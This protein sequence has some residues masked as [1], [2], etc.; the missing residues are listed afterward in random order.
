MMQANLALAALPFTIVYLLQ[1]LYRIN[2]DTTGDFVRRSRARLRR[3]AMSCL[4]AVI[5]CPV[6]SLCAQS[7]T[8]HITQRYLNIPVERASEMRLLTISVGGVQKREFPVQLAERATD[9]WIFLD[10]SEFEGST[11]TL[12]GPSGIASP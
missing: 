4:L 8:F 6:T 2:P 3:Q 7:R 11:T 10:V 5:V 12:A 9:Y 1:V